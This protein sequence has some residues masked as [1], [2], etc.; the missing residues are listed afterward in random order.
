MKKHKKLCIWS[1]VSAL[2]LIAAIVTCV[3]F[4]RLHTVKAA[5]PVFSDMTAQGT[6]DGNSADSM[7][8]EENEGSPDTEGATGEVNG[9]G[10]A[11]EESGNTAGADPITIDTPDSSKKTF[12]DYSAVLNDKVVLFDDVQTKEIY[13]AIQTIE[14]K[15]TGVFVTVS[16]DNTLLSQL[17]KGD[18][19]VLED[20]GDSPFGETYFGKIIKVDKDNGKTTYVFDNPTFDEVFDQLKLDVDSM[21]DNADI[22][23]V[24][25]M[26][27]VTVEFVDSVSIE[28]FNSG[29]VAANDAGKEDVSEPMIEAASLSVVD[30][31][32]VADDT[33]DVELDTSNGIVFN[34]SIDL[35][36]ALGI[37]DD[38]NAGSNNANGNGNTNNSSENDNG[39]DED[40]REVSYQEAYGIKVYRMDTVYTLE[41]E[42]YTVTGTIYHT[43]TCTQANAS[44]LG[45]GKKTVKVDSTLGDEWKAEH[46]PCV[47]CKPQIISSD[48]SID[49][50]SK[51]ENSFK[52]EGKAG[53]ENLYFKGDLDYD[54]KRVNLLE[55]LYLEAGGKIVTEA[56]LLVGGEYTLGGNTTGITLPNGWGKLEGLDEKLYPIACLQ[57][58]GKLTPAVLAGSNVALRQIN[59]DMP[60]S[61]TLLFYIDVKGNLTIQASAGFKY[62]QE[63]KYT[64]TIVKDGKWL[65]DDK[66]QTETAKEI[67]FD[68]SMEY[69]YDAHIGASVGFYVYNMNVAEIAVIKIGCEGEGTAAMSYAVQFDGP[70]SGNISNNIDDNPDNDVVIPEQS[71][72]TQK[73]ET[74]FEFYNRIYIKLIELNIRLSVQ[75]DLFGIID[76]S[77]SFEKDACF[78][79]WTLL[80]WGNKEETD[81]DPGEQKYDVAVARDDEAFYYIDTDYSLV[82]ETADKNR[83][84]LMEEVSYICAMDDKYIYVVAENE[85]TEQDCM[86]RVDK[87]RGGGRQIEEDICRV[88]DMD[89]KY[90]YYTTNFDKTMLK[91]LDRNTLNS[92]YFADFGR[93]VRCA[94]FYGDRIFVAEYQPNNLWFELR[95]YYWLDDE[96]NVDEDLGLEIDH[97]D[98]LIVNRDKYSYRFHPV[99]NDAFTSTVAYIAVVIDGKYQN[100]SADAFYIRE[101]GIYGLRKP[102]LLTDDLPVFFKFDL[103]T[104]EQIDLFEMNSTD[105]YY[106]LYGAADGHWYYLEDNEDEI[107]VRRTDSTF[108]EKKTIDTI[109]KEKYDI[110]LR[111]CD[112]S[113]SED[114][115]CFYR[116]DGIRTRVIYRLEL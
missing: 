30:T 32:D 68:V 92:H 80:E 50:S 86:Y 29:S 8:G 35:L 98:A 71:R 64:N 60:L 59:S 90:I 28:D 36:K 106:T 89:E 100:L 3:I 9:N 44:D 13:K 18:I 42:E 76:F 1:M 81:Y 109:N 40:D 17:G 57:Y 97:E 61:I 67:S 21:L 54:I 48:D 33:L 46:K 108:T 101:D 95:H 24:M 49:G 53:V 107:I 113:Y 87:K 45:D 66:L 58:D 77:P 38:D 83:M 7:T 23:D 84:V 99:D 51:W 85:V 112:V 65:W 47:L 115:L 20:Y 37:G 26:E 10:D 11:A 103:S 70:L 5:E 105:T 111:G 88:F 34:F 96:G 75:I 14:T 91:R 74:E 63:F 62:E 82:S 19:C 56:K 6:T 2:L 102:E 27:G 116:V 12:G 114:C 94:K 41:N 39:D 22:G 73:F 78:I 93:E 72:P 55:D 69:D 25:L 43:A 79:D 15:T 16:D 52:I 104:G 4:D 110:S 31:F